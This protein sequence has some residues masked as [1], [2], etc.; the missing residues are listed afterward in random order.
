MHCL[1]RV[2]IQQINR[3][4]PYRTAAVMVLPDMP[5]DTWAL[6]EAMD[7]LMATLRTLVV[8]LGE[9]GAQLAQIIASTRKPILLCNRL[10]S[11]LVSDPTERQRLL[12][13]T[14]PLERIERINDLAGEALLRADCPELSYSQFDTQTVN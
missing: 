3:L 8:K 9:K 13:N 14:N 1:A 5:V 6:D 7:G 10:G 11:A 12:E 2:R 4:L